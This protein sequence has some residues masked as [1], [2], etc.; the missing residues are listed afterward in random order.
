MKVS[1]KLDSYDCAGI[2]TNKMRRCGGTGV[3]YASC[4]P[5]DAAPF[6]KIC[7]TDFF[8]FT[9]SPTPEQPDFA[10]ANPYIS[11]PGGTRNPPVLLSPEMLC[12]VRQH[13]LSGNS[14]RKRY[15]ILDFPTEN[16]VPTGCFHPYWKPGSQGTCSPFTIP[17]VLKSVPQTKKG[18]CAYTFQNRN[19]RSRSASKE[20][21][22]CGI[23]A[24]VLHRE[25]WTFTPYLQEPC[26]LQTRLLESN[27]E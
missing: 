5:G 10:Q 9:T 13:S 21:I 4:S 2:F 19:P 3:W 16:R 7:L 18:V 26:F 11:S 8:R 24:I 17:A 22:D 27:N 15:N 20:S 6:Q 12:L 14:G 23:H 1:C 25:R